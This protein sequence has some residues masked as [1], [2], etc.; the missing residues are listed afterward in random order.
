MFGPIRQMKGVKAPG[1]GFPRKLED[2]SDNSP[3]WQARRRKR[4]RLEI[5][6]R[7]E[8]PRKHYT[9]QQ[10]KHKHVDVGRS[11][12]NPTNVDHVFSRLVCG[13][14]DQCGN[15]SHSVNKDPIARGDETTPNP[16]KV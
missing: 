3:S 1:E 5:P 9:D 11:T 4:S 14:Q 12:L 15:Q 16:N 10:R 8:I 6:K 13:K 7:R 2:A